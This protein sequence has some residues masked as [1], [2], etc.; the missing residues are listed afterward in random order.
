[1]LLLE[2]P[3]YGEAEVADLDR[4]RTGPGGLESLEEAFLGELKCGEAD[5]LRKCV[6]MEGESEESS[7]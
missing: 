1:M 2:L 5:A 4:K 7:G 3:K 6:E